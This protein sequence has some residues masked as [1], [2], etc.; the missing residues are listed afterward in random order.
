LRQIQ[1]AS[2]S[3]IRGQ[4]FEYLPEHATVN[5][6]LESPMARLVWRK[7]FRQ[8]L[9]ARARSQDPQNAIEYLA[10]ILA[11]SAASIGS[12]FRFEQ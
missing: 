5:P 8:I 3:Q 11:R 2:L 12:A 6:V 9:P 4:R 7:A 10:I 1:L